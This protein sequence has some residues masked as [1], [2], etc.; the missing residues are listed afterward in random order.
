M[1]KL[2][3]DTKG[4]K[5]FFVERGE[6]IAVGVAGLLLVGCFVLAIMAVLGPNSRSPAGDIDK[7]A[8]NL[9][10]QIASA[11]PPPTAEEPGKKDKDKIATGPQWT[12]GIDS[13]RYQ[14]SN[15]F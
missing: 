8:K 7:A 5:Q 1:A 4:L 6:L 12:H 14:T 15:W 3:L 2:K 11:V 10:Q 13:S 9:Q